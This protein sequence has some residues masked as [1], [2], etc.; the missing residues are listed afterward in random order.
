MSAEEGQAL[1]AGD[2]TAEHHGWL[3]RYD[4]DAYAEGPMYGPPHRSIVLIGIRRWTSSQG[5]RVGLLADTV[6]SGWRGVEY[7][8]SADTA[9]RLERRIRRGVPRPRKS[10]YPPA[11]A[12]S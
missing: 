2:L 4:L 5:E 9:V 10:D 1:K 8:V 12:A 7:H 3:I 11:E 6:D